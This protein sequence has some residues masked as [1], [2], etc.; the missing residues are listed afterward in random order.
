MP[1]VNWGAPNETLDSRHSL[2]SAEE[3]VII[4]SLWLLDHCPASTT[5][6]A[7]G[8]LCC[9]GTLLT[10]AQLAIYQQLQV[11]LSRAAPLLVR[12]QPLLLHGSSFFPSAGLVICPCWNLQAKVTK[13][14]LILRLF[15]AFS[16]HSLLWICLREN[17]GLIWTGF[18]QENNASMSELRLQHY[19]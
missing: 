13:F 14:C 10:P 9:T 18:R 19:I 16:V 4:T 6:E 5:S 1:L 15:I 2:T 12:F 8:L 7:F 11:F 3:R 17:I